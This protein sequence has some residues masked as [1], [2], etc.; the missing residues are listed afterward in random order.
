MRAM[1]AVVLA[2]VTAFAALA[3]GTATAATPAAAGVV[4]S[5][6]A[7]IFARPDGITAGPDGA[8]WFTNDGNNS[9][10]RI[11]DRRH[12]HATSPTPSISDPTGITAGPDGALWF[13]NSGE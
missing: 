2:A 1:P 8:L 11:T 3:S 10:G 6:S 13:T 9:I 7:G 12:G 4:T 5:F